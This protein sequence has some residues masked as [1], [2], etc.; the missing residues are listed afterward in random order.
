[1]ESGRPF[2]CP[3]RAIGSRPLWCVHFSRYVAFQFLLEGRRVTPRSKG[4]WCYCATRVI[5]Q[6]AWIGLYHLVMRVFIPALS[7]IPVLVLLA[8]QIG[9]G[10]ADDTNLIVRLEVGLPFQGVEIADTS[11]SSFQVEN[12]ETVN[13]TI[14]ISDS[15]KQN[16]PVSVEDTSALVEIQ[17]KNGDTTPVRFSDWGMGAPGVYTTTHVFG[18][19]GDYIILVQPDIKDR[20]T[21]HPEATDQLQVTVVGNA[22]TS[23]KAGS[24]IVAVIVSTLLIFLVVSMLLVTK[25]RRPGGRSERKPPGRAEADRETWWG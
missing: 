6:F 13:L 18:E 1:M 9:P 16:S 23:P 3:T 4:L 7:V 11:T 14:R 24:D 12:G 21:L 20:T 8:G 10:D 19:A 2:G 22:S 5:S 15:R 25:R 17:G